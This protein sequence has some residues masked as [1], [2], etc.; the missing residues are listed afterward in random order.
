MKQI[1]TVENQVGLLE[2]K[3]PQAAT[4]VDLTKVPNEEDGNGNVNDKKPSGW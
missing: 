3:S 1:K 4:V 2:P